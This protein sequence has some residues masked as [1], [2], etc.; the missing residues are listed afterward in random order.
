MKLD[1]EVDADDIDKLWHTGYMS[2]LSEAEWR[3]EAVKGFGFT[4]PNDKKLFFMHVDGESNYLQA[5]VVYHYYKNRAAQTAIFWDASD[6]S[7]WVVV[8]N[9]HDE[10]ARFN[11]L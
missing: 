2:T 4:F 11:D 8:T 3:L 9:D 7:G 10:I 1:I 5:L 6:G